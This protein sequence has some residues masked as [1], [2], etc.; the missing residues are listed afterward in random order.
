[1]SEL[2]VFLYSVISLA[3]HTDGQTAC[4]VGLARSL[5]SFPHVCVLITYSADFL[6]LY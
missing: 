1:M 4:V 2:P 5:I 6:I 3:K